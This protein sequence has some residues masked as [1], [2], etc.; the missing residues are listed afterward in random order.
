MWSGVRSIIS[1]WGLGPSASSASIATLP[2]STAH[3]VHAKLRAFIGPVATNVPQK[4]QLL[5]QV[6]NF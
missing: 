1:P 2:V 5:E 3:E 4:G 6:K